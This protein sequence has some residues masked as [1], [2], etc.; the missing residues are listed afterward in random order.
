MAYKTRTRVRNS[1]VRASDGQY[2]ESLVSR[3]VAGA[4]SG[5]SWSFPCKERITCGRDAVPEGKGHAVCAVVLPDAC[6]AFDRVRNTV[7]RESARD[8]TDADRHIT[9]TAKIAEAEGIKCLSPTRRWPDKERRAESIQARV[10]VRGELH[11][12]LACR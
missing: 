1:E 7:L 6:D 11:K 10:G 9:L 5:H 8:A 4:D 12:H 2:N 3:R